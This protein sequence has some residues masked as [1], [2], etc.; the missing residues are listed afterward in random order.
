[1]LSTVGD[2]AIKMNQAV[3]GY[4]TKE[5]LKS[6]TGIEPDEAIDVTETNEVVTE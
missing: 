6:L 5:N 4:F 3:P 1:M 2:G